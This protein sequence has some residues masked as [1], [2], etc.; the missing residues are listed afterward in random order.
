MKMGPANRTQN[1]TTNQQGKTTMNTESLRE[2][3]EVKQAIE[4]LNKRFPNPD[5]M[6]VDEDMGIWVNPDSHSIFTAETNDA[7]QGC[8][9]V[10]SLMDGEL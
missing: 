6:S 2:L 1:A 9:L 4:R 5:E 8:V 7:I 10:Y 3:P